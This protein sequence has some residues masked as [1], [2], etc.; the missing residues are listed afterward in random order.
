MKATIIECPIGI[1]AFDEKNNL[2]EKSLFP[3]V[4]KEAA[5]KL[6]AL[7]K[8]KSIN[9]LQVL[10]EN[11]KNRGYES[12]I[13]ESESLA[14]ILKEELKIEAEILKPAP[15]GEYLREN[16]EKLALKLKFIK[17]PEQLKN[18]IHNVTV[19]LTK[20]KVREAV[21][22]RDLLIIQAIQ[23]IDDIDKTTN[24]FMG[25]IREWYGLHFPELSRLIEKHETYA[26]II[27]E[28]GERE[29]FSIEKLVKLGLSEKKAEKIL[30]AAKASMGAPLRKED[31]ENLRAICKTTLELYERR[32]ELE[33]YVEEAMDEVAPNLKA[34]VGA[35]LGARLIALAG[36]LENLAK[37]PASTIQVLGAEKALFRAL[38]TGSKPPKHGVIFQHTYLR[39][40]RKWQRGK[41]A[42][43]LAGKL[44]IAARTDA[45]SGKYIGDELK[46]NLEK[47]IEEIKEKYSEPPQ[48]VYRP[49]KP[50]KRKKRRK[51]HGRS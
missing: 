37:M 40:A 43:A 10:V 2:L 25:R 34:L 5:E 51:K 42:R 32:R 36:S 49:S 29:N 13:V 9:E 20:L 7:K 19:E 24:L 33:R 50:K 3:K 16:L 17:K 44:A 41:I 23:T 31:L 4:P 45:Y 18:W 30:E 14:K 28:L 39:E 47:R 46:A 21:E 11:L 35:L 8:G 6:N 1:L 38:R 48:K 26:R 15:S 12:F 22:K 27:L